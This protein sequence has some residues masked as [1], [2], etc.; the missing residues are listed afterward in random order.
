M[1]TVG[2]TMVSELSTARMTDSE[3]DDNLNSRHTHLHVSLKDNAPTHW[4]STL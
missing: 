2:M 1:I 3:C 4:N